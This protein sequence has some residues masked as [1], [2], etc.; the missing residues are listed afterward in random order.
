R[1]RSA[2]R[3]MTCRSRSGSES[4]PGPT[5]PRTAKPSG[6]GG[7]RPAEC[8]PPG[9]AGNAR[10]RASRGWGPAAWGARPQKEPRRPGRAVPN[11]A[12]VGV[13]PFFND[14]A[15]IDVFEQSFYAAAEAAEEVTEILAWRAAPARVLDIG[16]NAGLHALEWARRGADVLGIDS[17]PV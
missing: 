7:S 14:R 1:R 3:A 17:A 6:T 5:R 4:S 9:V 12:A 2:T 10:L 11:K 8:A 15:T 13:D 16:C